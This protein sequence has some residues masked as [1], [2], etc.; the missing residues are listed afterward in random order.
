VSNK[1]T[2]SH[3]KLVN[4]FL[5]NADK[6]IVAL[7][8]GVDSAVVALAAKEALGDNAMAIT[9]NYKTLSKEEISAAKKIAAEILI[10]HQI[11]S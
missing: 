2:E 6:V 1:S 4:W 11:I 5:T 10:N 8:G 7:S 3:I 9:A